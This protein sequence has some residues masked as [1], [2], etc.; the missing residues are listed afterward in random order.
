MPGLEEFLAQ[1]QAL[2][3][4]AVPL[5][6]VIVGLVEFF[7]LCGLPSDAYAAGASIGLGILLLLAVQAAA[8]FPAA[9]PWILAVIAGA[10]LGM[11]ATGLYT[12]GARWTK[13]G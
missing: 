11:T 8:V 12:I 3:D 6:P 2:L 9:A 5:I 1:L 13:K 10:V 4:V 7:K